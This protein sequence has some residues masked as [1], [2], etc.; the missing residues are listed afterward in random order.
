[1]IYIRRRK[2][3]IILYRFS[4][5]PLEDVIVPGFSSKFSFTFFTRLLSDYWVDYLK[6]IHSSREPLKPYRFSPVFSGRNALFKRG[7]NHVVVL[8]AGGAYWFNVALIGFEPELDFRDRLRVFDKELVVDEIGFVRKEFGELVGGGVE[9]FKMI[10]LTPTL[11]SPKLCLPPRLR[12][13]TPMSVLRLYPQPCLW[14]RSLVLFWNKYAPKDLKLRDGYKLSRLADIYLMETGY[15]V[16]PITA[17]YTKNRELIEHRGFMGWI[18][19]KIIDRDFAEKIT[20][21]LRLAQ[22][23]GVGRSRSIGFGYTNIEF[24]T[25]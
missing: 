4:F 2:Y 18:K 17:Y 15:D 5:S 12:I 21:L 16:K 13:E 23:F 7:R 20:P 1:M 8:R 25:T 9:S 6:K 24:E 10:F 14:V 22:L 19:Y 3:A 11:L